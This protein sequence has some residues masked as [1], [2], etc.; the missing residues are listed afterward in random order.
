MEVEE[1]EGG[2]CA[3]CLEHLDAASVAILKTCKHIFC[4]PCL[5]QNRTDLCPLCRGQYTEDD[6]VSKNEVEEA[7]S[8]EAIKTDQS[9][10]SRKQAAKYALSLGRSPKI[11]ALLDAV[12]FECVCP[13]STK[14]F[15]TDRPDE[16]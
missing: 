6:I 2:E 11:E 4:Q 14:V 12:S 7:V 15:E 10:C 1:E 3:I 8:N 16:T 5:Q 13:G 9:L